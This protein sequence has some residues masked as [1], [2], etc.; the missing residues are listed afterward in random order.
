MVQKPMMPMS[1]QLATD[2][3]AISV[4]FSF[5]G[6]PRLYG[7]HQSPEG[8]GSS[9]FA[10]MRMVRKLVSSLVARSAR[11]VMISYLAGWPR[12]PVPKL[13]FTWFWRSWRYRRQS[14]GREPVGA[15]QE[16]LAGF[17]TQPTASWQVLEPH[18]LFR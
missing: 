6:S 5:L 7:A 18:S 12:N 9:F 1:Y 14:V 8:L 10:G 13:S 4:D 11:S 16:L 2:M 3:V 17:S 15:A